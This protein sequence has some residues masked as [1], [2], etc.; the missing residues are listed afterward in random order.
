MKKK[1]SAFTLAEVLITLGILGVIAAISLPNLASNVSATQLAA[2][3]KT[4]QAS[5]SDKLDAALAFEDVPNVRDLKAFD[6]TTLPELYKGLSKYLRLDAVTEDHKVYALNDGSLVETWKAADIR[7]TNTKAFIY[8]TDFTADATSTGTLAIKQ[9]GGQV[10]RRS[11]IVYLDVNGYTK[12]NRYG[13]DVYK[14]YLAQNGR[15]YPVG[16]SDVSLFD[17]NGASDESSDWENGNENYACNWN[18]VGYGCAGRIEDEG[19]KITYFGKRLK[20]KKEQSNKTT[21]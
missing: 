14:Y 8:I 2:S 13:Y 12:P 19:W 18:S 3:L 11:A 5:I 17:T 20:D 21:G 6:C 7:Q 10:L 4:T 1:K 9:N 15:L 16:G